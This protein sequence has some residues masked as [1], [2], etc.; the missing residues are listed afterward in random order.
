[1]KF[2][3][4]FLTGMDREK[5]ISATEA[6]RQFSRLIDGVRRGRTFLVTSHGRPVARIS[7][8]QDSGD[9]VR[10]ARANLLTQLRKQKPIRIGRW[11][12]DELYE[13]QR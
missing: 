4:F 9:V 3:I 12:R 1:M 5:A 8:V 10:R 13:D 7:P 2:T 11:K 6:N